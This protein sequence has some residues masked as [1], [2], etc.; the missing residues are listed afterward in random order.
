MLSQ[1]SLLPVSPTLLQLAFKTIS[2][3]ACNTGELGQRGCSL[4]EAVCADCRPATLHCL[5]DS[6]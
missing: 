6:P 5:H 3:D 1:M 4:S 2:T